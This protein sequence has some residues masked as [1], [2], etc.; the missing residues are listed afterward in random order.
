MGKSHGT[1]EYEV[2]VKTGPSGSMS[3]GTFGWA[4]I[5]TFIRYGR[6]DADLK[7]DEERRKNPNATVIVRPLE[8]EAA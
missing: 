2:V 8:M 4:S 3:D 6:W 5:K 7:A 1:K